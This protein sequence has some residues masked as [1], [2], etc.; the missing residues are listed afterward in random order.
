MKVLAINGSARKN[1]NTD[2]LFDRIF[3]KLNVACIETE[4]VQF[5]GNN[6]QPCRAC[7]ACGGKEN[8]IYKQDDFQAVFEKMKM[9]EGILLGSPSI[10]RIYRPICRPFWSGRQL[11]AI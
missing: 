5:A 11:C 4:V 9:A 1:G 7:F 6:I 8:C 3:E 10:P 2:I